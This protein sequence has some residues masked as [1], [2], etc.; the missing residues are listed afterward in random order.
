MSEL[1]STEA[2]QETSPVGEQPAESS[3]DSGDASTGSWPKDVQAEFTK[4]SQGLADER[5]TFEEGRQKWYSQQQQLQHQQQQYQQQQSRQ[6]ATA[7]QPNPTNEL[8]TQLREMQYLDGPTAATLV[9]RIMQEGINPLSQAIHQRDQ[10]L[11]HLYKEYKSVKE[12]LGQHTSAKAETEMSQRF[13]KL[14][15]DHQLPDEPW[16][17]EYLQ[18]VYYSHE[19][20][21][22]NTEYPNM[23]RQRLDTMRKGFREMDRKAAETARSQSSF[24]AKGG[25]V[26]FADGKTGGYKSPEERTNELWPMLNPGQ[27]E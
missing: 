26:S 18:D 1:E 6:Q 15:E 14:R 5:R 12:G 13:V 7:A 20:N 3:P 4:K 2:L 17:N 23:V 21:D 10:A 24:P 16:V 25:E 22:L 11:A 27:S 8:L 9:E 19:G